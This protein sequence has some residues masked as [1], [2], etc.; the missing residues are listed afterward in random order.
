MELISKSFATGLLLIK[1]LW[2]HAKPGLEGLE[3]DLK[4]FELVAADRSLFVFEALDPSD[5]TLP[6]RP[7]IPNP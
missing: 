3:I 2:D 4:R 7:P 1:P 5:K 6:R